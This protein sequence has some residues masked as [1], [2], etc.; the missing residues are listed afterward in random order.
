MSYR[1]AG[2]EPGDDQKAAWQHA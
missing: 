1:Q 2:V